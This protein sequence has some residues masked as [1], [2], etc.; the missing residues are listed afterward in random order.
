MERNLCTRYLSDIVCL[1]P[2]RDCHDCDYFNP[3]NMSLYDRLPVEDTP[4]DPEDI[5]YDDLPF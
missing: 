2:E 3:D 1:D 4:D 5:T